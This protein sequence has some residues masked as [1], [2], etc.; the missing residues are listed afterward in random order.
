LAGCYFYVSTDKSPSTRQNIRLKVDKVH[1][2]CKDA[3]PNLLSFSTA[4]RLSGYETIL[5]KDEYYDRVTAMG[6]DSS[7]VGTER[8]FMSIISKGTGKKVIALGSDNVYFY[9]CFQAAQGIIDR[10]YNKFI[11]PTESILADTDGSAVL[12]EIADYIKLHDHKLNEEIVAEVFKIGFDLNNKFKIS[13]RRYTKLYGPDENN[14]WKVYAFCGCARAGTSGVGGSGTDA[15]IT[16]GGTTVTFGAAID[17]NLVRVGMALRIDSTMF[18]IKSITDS[19]HVVVD[20]AAVATL[21][22][23]DYSMGHSYHTR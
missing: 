6:F 15:S 17:L 10:L 21:S 8:N 23:K 2:P 1:N 7:V 9:N 14:P 5:T 11:N 12:V 18:W 20:A 3:P 4:D 19:T 13:A 16:I 22:N